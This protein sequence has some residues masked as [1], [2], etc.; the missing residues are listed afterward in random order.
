MKNGVDIFAD[1]YGDEHGKGEHFGA[2]EPSSSQAAVKSVEPDNQKRVR[3]KKQHAAKDVAKNE[4]IFGE[5]LMGVLSAP[6]EG[7]G[8]DIKV[9]FLPLLCVDI[10][11][12]RIVGCERLEKCGCVVDVFLGP[13]TFSLHIKRIEY[14]TRRR[15]EQAYKTRRRSSSVLDDAL[16]HLLCLQ[17]DDMNDILDACARFQRMKS[18]VGN[19]FI[20]LGK[21]ELEWWSGMPIRLEESTSLRAFA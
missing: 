1:L 15:L 5:N 13:S 20:V 14:L 12:K 16:H 6:F 8:A 3:A 19:P 10:E 7:R 21:D 2:T 17:T 9:T 4:S 11:R 18:S